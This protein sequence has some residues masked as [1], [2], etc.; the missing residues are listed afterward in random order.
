VQG[1]EG[2]EA[3]VLDVRRRRDDRIDVA[4]NL[5]EIGGVRDDPFRVPVLAIGD[6]Q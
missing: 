4:A 1:I 6:R 2:S 5:D 3:V